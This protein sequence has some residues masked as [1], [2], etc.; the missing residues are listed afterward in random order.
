MKEWR[1]VGPSCP[2]QVTRRTAGCASS[3]RQM[4]PRPAIA[5]RLEMGRIRDCSFQATG[6]GKRNCI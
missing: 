5:A 4:L 3:G 6:Y 1:E 2:C